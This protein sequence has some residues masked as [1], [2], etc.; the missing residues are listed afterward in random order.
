MVEPEAIPYV[1]LCE[2]ALFCVEAGQS[3][4][5][6]RGAPMAGHVTGPTQVNGLHTPLL[7]VRVVDPEATPYVH[8]WVLHD[9]PSLVPGHNPVAQVGGLIPGHAAAAAQV[10]LD[11]WPF[12]HVNTELVPPT[13]P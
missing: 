3:P 13:T 11:H 8:D 7:H 2:H 10:K 9:P 12:I 6:Y 1:Q 5:P 4:V